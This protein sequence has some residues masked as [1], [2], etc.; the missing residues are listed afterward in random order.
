M[1]VDEFDLLMRAL[2]REWKRDPESVHG[3]KESLFYGNN[4]QAQTHIFMCPDYVFAEVGGIE[5]VC[6]RPIYLS[7]K[8]RKKYDSAIAIFHEIQGNNKVVPETEK[9]ICDT[10]PSAKDII[11]ERALVNDHEN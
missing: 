3:K 4:T 7:R 1:S 10:I 8:N 11:A 6:Y 2:H 5:Y 9:L